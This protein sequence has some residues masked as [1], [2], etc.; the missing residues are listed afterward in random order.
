MTV[1]SVY[2]C[3][4]P[5]F[6]AISGCKISLFFLTSVSGTKMYGCEKNVEYS[7]LFILKSQENKIFSSSKITTV[8]CWKI[9]DLRMWSFGF[10]WISLSSTSRIWRCICKEMDCNLLEKCGPSMWSLEVWRIFIYSFFKNF[11]SY[12]QENLF[13]TQKM[14]ISCT[15]LANAWRHWWKSEYWVSPTRLR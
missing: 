15:T 3:V 5:K 6:P 8:S 9:Q 4:S 1:N 11:T 12:M 14:G 13:Q 7:Q 10:L 2:M